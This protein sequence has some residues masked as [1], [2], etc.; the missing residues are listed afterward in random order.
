MEII[1]LVDLD[2]F[3]SF[4]ED[5][6]EI[7]EL[8]QVKKIEVSDK[9]S[10]KEKSR[11]LKTTMRRYIDGDFLFIDCDTVICDDFS[12]FDCDYPMAMV[13]DRNCKLS[14]RRDGGVEIK[15]MAQNCG[16]DLS[17][18]DKYFNSGVVWVKDTKET[19]IFFDEWHKYWKETLKI[20]MCVDQL[21]LNHV[22]SNIKK[23]VVGELDGIWNCQISLN[24]A[25]T[26]YI[27]NAH[28]IHYF[29]TKPSSPYLLCNEKLIREYRNSSIINTIILN[30]RSSFKKSYFITCGEEDDKL[31]NSKQGKLLRMMYE[32]HKNIYEFN[33]K[34]L[35]MVTN[36][37]KK[38]KPNKIWEKF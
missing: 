31:L 21:S 18:C 22:I 8:A 10:Q 2:T 4:D 19:R 9:Y 27:A 23:D 33:E 29:N 7:F 20:G 25:G 36:I 12:K 28:I 37:K 16:F 3:E 15:R 38:I 1:V 14:D 11:Y 13:L 34:I 5:R 26:Q 17:D 6:K 35:S 32:K 30:P 24:P